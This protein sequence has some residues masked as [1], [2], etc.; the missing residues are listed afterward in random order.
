MKNFTVF[1]GLMLAILVAFSGCAKK[2]DANKP[3]DQVQAEAQ[4]MTVSDL[5]S[6]ARAYADAIVA[7]KGDLEKVGNELKGIK[8]T[9][10]LGEK[11][12]SLKDEAARIGTEMSALTQRY[13][14][15]AKKFQELGGDVAKI[16]IA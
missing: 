2:A 15:Y 11:A 6:T 16:Q 1:T 7:K 10:M 5:Q 9:E 14:V 13:E 4:K 8:I 3:L 12:K